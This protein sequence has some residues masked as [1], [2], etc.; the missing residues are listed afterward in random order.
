MDVRF[1]A[2]CQAANKQ[3]WWWWWW[4]L[5]AE[6]TAVLFTASWP[7]FSV[8]TITHEPLD[9]DWW[10]FAR[11]CTLTTARSLLNSKVLGQRSRSH[12]FFVFLCPWYPRAVP[13]SKGF[14]CSASLQSWRLSHRLTVKKCAEQWTL[15]ITKQPLFIW[16]AAGLL[17]A[18]CLF[19]DKLAR[20]RSTESCHD[21]SIDCPRLILVHGM[22]VLCSQRFVWPG[23]RTRYKM[24]RKLVPGG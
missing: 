16:R 18:V 10:N 19:D 5:P 12:G 3:T 23:S 8:N 2:F 22:H 4:W 24:R 7:I 20:E 11:T 21:L 14:A 6:A 15:C 17:Q 1:L 9:L 13:L